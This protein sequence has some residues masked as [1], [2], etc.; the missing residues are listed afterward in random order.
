MTIFNKRIKKLLVGM[1]SSLLLVGQFSP[2]ILSVAE[3]Q[4]REEVNED[5]LEEEEI[6]ESSEITEE[7]EEETSEE[8]ELL[9]DGVIDIE[10]E[11]TEEHAGQYRLFLEDNPDAYL[12]L[13]DAFVEFL[14][15]FDTLNDEAIID[16]I[17]AFQL[18]VDDED[19]VHS[20]FYEDFYPDQL[21]ASKNEDLVEILHY[22]RTTNHFV[23][24][25]SV[26][27]SEPQDMLMNQLVETSS[28]RNTNVERISGQDRVA[29]SINVSRRGWSNSNTVVIANGY[30]FT[31]A[32]SGTPLAA[33][34]G[35]P[36]LLVNGNTITNAT[37]NEI[38]RLGARNIIVLGGPDSVS[39][40]IL[41]TLR[42]RGL[43]V[44]RI[45]GQN[46]YDTSRKI[47]DRLISL[48]GPSTA[49]LVNGEAYAD[50]VSISSVAGRYRQ[51]ILLTQSNQLH[52]EVQ[53]IANT[54]KDWRIIG[55][56]NSVSNNVENQLRSRVNNVTRLSGA[57]RYEVNRR[58]LNN[59][60]ISGSKV[61]VGH[62]T[63]FA[64]VLSGSVLAA[65]ENTGVLLTSENAT[66]IANV[67]QYARSRN[68]D[69]F[70]LLG[71]E[72]TLNNQIV[73][74]FQRLYRRVVYIDPGHGGTD[75]G[76]SFGG[77]HEKDLALSLALRIRDQLL[78]TGNYD[79]VMSR[80]TDTF[81]PLAT[82]SR[83]A[84]SRN[85]D[86]FVSI[87][88]NSM[89]GAGTARGIESFIYNAGGYTTTPNPTNQRLRSS[90]QLANQITP[91]VAS[92]TGLNNRG[93]R[94]NNLH[95]VR[96]TNMPAV[97]MEYGFID[98]ATERNIVRQVTY[99]NN[100][101]QATRDGINRY[102]GF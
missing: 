50:A 49:H 101:A 9:D 14:E 73:N 37:L 102:F 99:Q 42:N 21:G 13:N 80:T 12:Y 86:I 89:G 40:S 91:L 61:Y 72:R 2:N 19:R 31:D 46:R 34:Y 78:A 95:V 70:V 35:A 67:Q 71:G 11:K 54:V 22:L 27:F 87:H 18:F 57:D 77:V 66:E 5:I 39:E 58:V 75:P 44:E 26:S 45:A 68:L 3:S 48:R 94:G 51:P 10:E 7:A 33:H 32:L 63:A 92:R 16:N 43:S 65:R 98:N 82:R 69:H 38:S 85:V 17:D 83:D 76:A 41:N 60:G 6:E 59:W 79:V 23:E 30:R 52:P 64:D 20:M 81:I 29:V 55:G 8:N 4:E 88:F 74:A 93:V 96:E 56:P 24:E 47:A 84:N 53:Q 97:L 90:L 1:S 36:M 100:A 15:E 28:T 62:G 25:E